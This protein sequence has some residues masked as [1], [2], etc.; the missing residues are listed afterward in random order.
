MDREWGAQSAVARRLSGRGL[1]VASRDGGGGAGVG[2][3]PGGALSLLCG[4][5]LGIRRR[6]ISRM[7]RATASTSSQLSFLASRVHRPDQASREKSA[8][9]HVS[10]AG[11]SKRNKRGM[12]RSSARYLNREENLSP[13]QL[14]KRRTT[15][16]R[17]SLAAKRGAT[18][19]RK[20]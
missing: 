20:E 13:S 9:W 12:R 8:A 3:A 17:N 18:W 7:Y 1:G 19:R 11:M 15:V 10:S 14:W 16:R 2:E 6:W 4:W 5:G